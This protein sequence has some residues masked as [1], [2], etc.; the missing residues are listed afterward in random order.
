M[1]LLGIGVVDVELPTLLREDLPEDRPVPGVDKFFQ[2]R[3]IRRSVL[4]C[5][6]HSIFS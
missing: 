3:K 2:A 5:Q 1:V 4:R 6:I